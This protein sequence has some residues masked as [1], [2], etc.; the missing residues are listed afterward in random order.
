MQLLIAILMT[1]CVAMP[2]IADQQ[3]TVIG[4]LKT[5]DKLVIM[6]LGEDAPLFTIKDQNGKVIVSELT[7]DQ[8]REEHE[9]LHKIIKELIASYLDASL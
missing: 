7:E 4:Q 5:R 9:D 6:M 3:A 1:F 2:A 8:I